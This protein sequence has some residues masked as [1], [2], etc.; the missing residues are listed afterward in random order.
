[1]GKP[2]CARKRQRHGPLSRTRFMLKLDDGSWCVRTPAGQGK[3]EERYN[4]RPQF[5]EPVVWKD[6][7]P[8]IGADYDGNGIGEVVW[9]AKKP[10]QVFRSPL[11]ATDRRLN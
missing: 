1:V 2:R 4:G 3:P 11:R 7:W 6:G 10:V 9:S 5:L 8:L